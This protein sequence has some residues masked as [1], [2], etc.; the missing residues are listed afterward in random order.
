MRRRTYLLLL[1][2][3]AVTS[4]TWAA[5]PLSGMDGASKRRPACDCDFQCESG[6]C[7]T[8]P[9]TTGPPDFFSGV[10]R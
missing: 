1:G 6:M 4:M 10:C 8:V 3:L 7:Q 9:C 2:L 5:A